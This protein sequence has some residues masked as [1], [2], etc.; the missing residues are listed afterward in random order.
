MSLGCARQMLAHQVRL[1][2]PSSLLAPHL[3][4]SSFVPLTFR[5]WGSSL[6]TPMLCSQGSP[7]TS[8]EAR[9]SS[10][11]I[12]CPPPRCS[13]PSPQ[14]FSACLVGVPRP[15]FSCL[16]L[17]VSPP[18]LNAPLQPWFPSS[19]LCSTDS[20]VSRPPTLWSYLALTLACF[21]QSWGWH[22]S[23]LGISIPKAF[24]YCLPLSWGPHPLAEGVS[25]SPTFGSS[26]PLAWGP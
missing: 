25:K 26:L 14:W 15:P 23:I 10:P 21:P 17:R 12:T 1:P 24:G 7:P 4:T 2:A 3:S 9:P 13:I 22:I 18:A 5:Y 20:P 8:L 19:V 11:G 16:T 6:G